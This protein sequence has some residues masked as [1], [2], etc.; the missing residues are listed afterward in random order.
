M[1][2]VRQHSRMNKKTMIVGLSSTPEDILSEVLVSSYSHDR[3]LETHL[4][5]QDEFELIAVESII[6]KES[7]KPC[8]QT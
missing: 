4:A 7:W 1:A 6:G 3:D 2:F 8:P 5:E